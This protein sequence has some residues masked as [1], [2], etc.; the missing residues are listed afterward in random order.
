LSS[1]SFRKYEIV[2]EH[3]LNG[4]STYLVGVQAGAI[5]DPDL[6]QYDRFGN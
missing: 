2:V 5:S 3:P 1:P 4:V 6:K